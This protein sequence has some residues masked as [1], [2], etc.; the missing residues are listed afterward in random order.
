MLNPGASF[1]PSKMWPADRYAALGDALIEKWGAQVIVNAAPAERAV[2]A[3]VV[4][5]MKHKLLLHFADRDNS[6]G[7]LKGLLSRTDLLVTND[8]GARHVGAAMGAAVVT[9]FG[10]TD[11]DWTRLDYPRE[12]LVRTAVECAPCQKKRCR[13]PAG[14]T[15]HR[16]MTAIPVEMVLAA[17]EELLQGPRAPRGGPQA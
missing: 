15:R 5:A 17:A 1:G 3:A 12:R 7:L 9:I 6:L 10:S 8:T 14:P 2:A 13:L 4:A 11:P 16:C